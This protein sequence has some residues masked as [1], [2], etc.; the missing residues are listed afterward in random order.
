MDAGHIVLGLVAGAL[1]AGAAWLLVQRGAALARAAAAEQ[2]AAGERDRREQ[3]EKAHA[4]LAA[5]IEKARAT[6]NATQLQAASLDAKA[7]ALEEARGVYEKERADLVRSLEA[8]FGSMASAVLSKSTEDFLRLAKESQTALHARATGEIEKKRVEIQSLVDPIRQTLEKTDKTLA[9]MKTQWAEDRGQLAEQIRGVGTSGELLRQETGKLVKA[10]G[11][12]EVRGR[13]GNIQLRR[14]VEIAGM[15]AYC[16]F[17]ME[18]TVRDD[19]GRALRPDMT[20]RLPNERLLVVDA[21]TNINEY[22]EAIGAGEEA[23]RERH[24]D[25]FA[26]HVSE[27]VRKLSDKAYWDQFERAPDFVV[28]YVPGD[29]FLDTA[30]ARRPDLIEQATAQRVILASPSTLIGLLRVVELGWKEQHLTRQAQELRSLGA[31]LHE[32]AARVWELA[33]K[34]G[35]AL[36]RTVRAYNEFVG[37]V[38]GRLTPTLRRFEEAGVQSAKSVEPPEASTVV[39]RRLESGRPG[40]GSL[41][42]AGVTDS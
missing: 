27:Q 33:S 2:D 21:K 19:D 3:V 40:S 5:E 20:V 6:L 17:A 36:D 23:E 35:D 4:D 8:K 39:V 10:L 1:G 28:M 24:L 15:R 30:Y 25:R 11:K 22:V 14:L 26:G 13:Y 41:P 31:E 12:P 16:D 9:D 37:S 7:K 29:Q 42:G 38:D 34:V 32:R 18:T